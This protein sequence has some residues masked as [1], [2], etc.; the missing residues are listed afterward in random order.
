MKKLALRE[1]LCVVVVMLT[2]RRPVPAE[3]QGK[4]ME[5]A[6]EG[7]VRYS[8]EKKKTGGGGKDENGTGRNI[9]FVYMYT[10]LCQVWELKCGML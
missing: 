2:S 5:K 7:R 6:R 9:V 10:S 8:G 4:E 3:T 1:E